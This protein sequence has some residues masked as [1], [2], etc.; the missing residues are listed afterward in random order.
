MRFTDEQLEKAWAELGDIPINNDD[1][2]EV[3]YIPEA[4]KGEEIWE[5]RT[6]RFE[7]WAFF[8]EFYS[9]GTAYLLYGEGGSKD[10]K[11]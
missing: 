1:E 9:K 2:I 11:T 4:L 3:D 5:T 10:E 6:D 7:I 8:D